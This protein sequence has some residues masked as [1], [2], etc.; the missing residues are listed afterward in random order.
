MSSRSIEVASATRTES[1]GCNIASRGNRKSD[2]K[3]RVYVDSVKWQTLQVV[4]VPLENTGH[5]GTSFDEVD[6]AHS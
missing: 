4:I 5:V 2:V 3:Q 6:E 1:V